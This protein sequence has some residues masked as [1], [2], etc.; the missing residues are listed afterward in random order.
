MAATMSAIPAPDEMKLSSSSE[1]VGATVVAVVVLGASVDS[2]VGSSV[3]V[4]VGS[5]VVVS[6][7]VVASVVVVVGSGCAW[8]IDAANRGASPGASPNGGER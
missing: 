7:V 1:D 6:D 8:A 3:V 4:V 5:V 2:V